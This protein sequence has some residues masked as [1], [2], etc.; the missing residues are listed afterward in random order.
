MIKEEAEKL[1]QEIKI[2]ITQIV[3]EEWEM[4]IL[5]TL[6]AS[7]LG[8]KIYLKGGTALRL[9]YGSPRFSEDLDFNQTKKITKFEF[10]QFIQNLNKQYPRLKV[11]DKQEK[12]YTWLV[13]FKIFENYLARNFSV[14]IEISKRATK[15]NKSAIKLLV[16]PTTNLEVLARVENIEDI[17]KEKLNALKTRGKSRDLFDL[18][19]ISQKLRTILPK[20][21]PKLPKRLIR[22]ELF[23]FLSKDYKSIITDLENNYGK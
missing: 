13:Q 21:L 5:R 11:S 15:K 19:Y 17:Y 1:A 2:D 18:W 9:A 23:K 14:K 6:F 4:K 12:Y 8:K 10:D 7:P 20:N 3:R 22:Q 16:S